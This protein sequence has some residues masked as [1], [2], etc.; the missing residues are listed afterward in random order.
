MNFGLVNP[1]GKVEIFI[2]QNRVA[3]LNIGYTQGDEVFI[4]NPQMK[5]LMA[6]KASNLEELFPEKSD[7]VEEVKETVMEDA[8]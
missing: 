8:E 3:E 5:P 7:L 1:E 6:I 2:G 4:Y